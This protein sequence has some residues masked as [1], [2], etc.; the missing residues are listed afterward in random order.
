[1]AQ[2]NSLLMNAI[3][4]SDTQTLDNS[5]ANNSAVQSQFALFP[6]SEQETLSTS[7]LQDFNHLMTALTPKSS[8]AP[9]RLAKTNLSETKRGGETGETLSQNSTK[10][11]FYGLK[12]ETYTNLRLANGSVDCNHKVE[13]P[14]FH[15]PGVGYANPFLASFIEQQ[16]KSEVRQINQSGR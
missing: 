5:N 4:N 3:N 2:A 1:M 15:L 9:S 6:D 8:T 10:Q 13:N 11:G 12:A 14:F 16:I 7:C